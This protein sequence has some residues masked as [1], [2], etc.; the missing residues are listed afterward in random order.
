MYSDDPPPYDVVISQEYFVTNSVPDIVNQAEANDNAEDEV[1]QNANEECV[2][3]PPPSYEEF[4]RT[5]RL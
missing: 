3:A 2:E 4:M 5:S 1:F